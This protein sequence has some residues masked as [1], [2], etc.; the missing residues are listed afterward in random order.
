MKQIFALI[1]FQVLFLS[2]LHS[3][4]N[5]AENWGGK[6]EFKKLFKQEMCYPEDALIK[7]YGGKVKVEFT[8]DDQG[9]PKNFQI[10]KSVSKSVNA[11]ALRLIQMCIWEPAQIDG[12]NVESKVVQSCTFNPYVYSEWLELR[13]ENIEPIDFTKYPLLE[14]TQL[15]Q[16]PKYKGSSGSFEE[17]IKNELEYPIE[18]FKLKINGIVEIKFVVEPTGRVTNVKISKSLEANC[19]IE[20]KRVVSYGQWQ[21]G[22]QNGQPVRTVMT[23]QIRFTPGGVGRPLQLPTSPITN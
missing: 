8:I 5:K 11:E 17:L 2:T 1:A 6:R 4:N 14:E 12:E 20:A 10:L 23:R 9:V 21:P 18:A 3:Q 22:M 13:N 15:D 19:D 7:K 16:R